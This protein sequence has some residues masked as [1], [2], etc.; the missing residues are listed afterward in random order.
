M[1]E[2]KKSVADQDRLISVVDAAEQ[3]NVNPATLYRGLESGSIPLQHVR[4]G[5][6]LIRIRESAVARYIEENT[7]YV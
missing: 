4:V 2:L 3:L 7:K 6:R 5:K 1:E